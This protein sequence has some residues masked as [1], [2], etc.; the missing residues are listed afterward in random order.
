MFE[1][2]WD[3]PPEDIANFEKNYENDWQHDNKGIIFFMIIQ[4]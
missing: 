4:G 3:M 1:N 2:E